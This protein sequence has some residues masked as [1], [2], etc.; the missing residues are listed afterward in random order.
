MSAL[1]V[2][3]WVTPET[4]ATTDTDIILKQLIYLLQERRGG[5]ELL[6]R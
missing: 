1:I 5:I 3:E 2:E 4:P 6:T